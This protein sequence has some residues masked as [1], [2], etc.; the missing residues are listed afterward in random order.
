MDGLVDGMSVN[1]TKSNLE[2]AETAYL[3]DEQDVR[4]R[5]VRAR[6]QS[7]NL[8]NRTARRMVSNPQ[9]TLQT[10]THSSKCLNSL[11]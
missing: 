2:R 1:S 10:S 8:A 5:E 3:V 4:V 11:E 7:T 6:Y 9:I